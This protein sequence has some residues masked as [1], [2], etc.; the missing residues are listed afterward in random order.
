[1]HDCVYKE[2]KREV[3]AAAPCTSEDAEQ[4]RSRHEVRTREVQALVAAM[5]LSGSSHSFLHCPALLDIQRNPNSCSLTL[6]CSPPK[7]QNSAEGLSA[8]TLAFGQQ[9]PAPLYSHWTRGSQQPLLARMP[10]GSQP[11]VPEKAELS[12]LYIPMGASMQ[13]RKCSPLISPHWG[14]GQE[15]VLH[16][17]SSRV[18]HSSAGSCK[19]SSSGKVLLLGMK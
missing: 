18:C 6:E 14:D 13:P 2:S 12:Q 17:L 9:P 15:P 3:P 11:P 7:H 5:S 4:H 10:A 19:G 8:E 1:M 16:D